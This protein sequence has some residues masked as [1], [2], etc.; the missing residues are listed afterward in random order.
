MT[1][2]GVKTDQGPAITEWEPGQRRAVVGRRGILDEPEDL[3]AFT[4]RGVTLL[5]LM[6]HEEGGVSGVEWW[7]RRYAE[8]QA[9]IAHSRECEH[10]AIPGD[11]ARQHARD[12]ERLE[13]ELELHRLAGP[14]R[15]YERA[16]HT[17]ARQRAVRS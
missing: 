15:N 9:A 13:E 6:Q 4:V 8:L 16:A 5:D 2:V 7:N 12:A 14:E 17:M 3:R 11:L 1:K 10:A